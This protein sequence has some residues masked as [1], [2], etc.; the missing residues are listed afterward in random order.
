MPAHT[1]GPVAGLHHVTAICGAPQENLDFYAGTLSQRLVKKTVNFDDPGTYHLYY[2]DET[3][4]P[5]TILTFFPFTGSAPGREGAGQ[6]LAYAYLAPRGK[7]FDDWV[8]RLDGLTEGPVTERFGARVLTLRDPHGQRLELIEGDVAGPGLGGFHSVTLWVR[9][10]A[11]TAR[12]LTEVFGYSEAGHQSARGEDRLR[13]VAQGA[14]MAS[15]VDIVRRDTA[16][17]ARQG[18]GSIHHIAFRAQDDSHQSA[19]REALQAAGHQVTP[20]IDRQY[21]NAIYFREPGGIL[22][23]VATDPPGFAVDEAQGV[24]GRA[25]CLPE[26]HEELRAR[27]EAHL[28]PLKLPA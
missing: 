7:R 20:Q 12:V 19:I 24:L 1:P 21:F 25:L 15:I 10:A 27:I 6:T 17:A 5:G 8:A 28:P 4:T 11:P 26:Q 16:P 14:G 2:G 18:A 23:E 3:G 13:F 22:F 9:D